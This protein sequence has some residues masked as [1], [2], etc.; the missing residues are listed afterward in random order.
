MWPTEGVLTS[1]APLTA[2]A[3]ENHHEIRNSHPPCHRIDR[4]NPCGCAGWSRARSSERVDHRD[5]AGA[6]CTW[7]LSVESL[8]AC[9]GVS[10]DDEVAAAT[11]PLRARRRKRACAISSLCSI[12]HLLGCEAMSDRFAPGNPGL[13][14]ASRG[15]R[16]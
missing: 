2:A 16:D 14:R 12:A 15:S 7:R 11:S 8:P 13:N 10:I 1:P 3:E 5:T 4:H 6:C 9:D